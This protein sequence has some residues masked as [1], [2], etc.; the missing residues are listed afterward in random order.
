MSPENKLPEPPRADIQQG[1]PRSKAKDDRLKRI[2]GQHPQRD[3]PAVDSVE[4]EDLPPVPAP[5]RRR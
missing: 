2:V 3:Q 4:Q 5:R 1:K